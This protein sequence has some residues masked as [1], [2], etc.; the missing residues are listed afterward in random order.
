MPPALFVGRAAELERFARVADSLRL[1]LV[2]G[3]EGIGKTAFLLRAA[4]DL[5]A[6]K[7][8]RLVY[9]PCRAGESAVSWATAL[10]EQLGSARR[11]DPIEALVAEAQAAPIVACL[12]DVHLV[13]DRSLVDAL[14]HLAERQL[15]LWLG[16]ASRQALPVSPVQVDHLVVR[17]EGLPPDE[18][19]SLWQGLA[20]LY[21]APLI[22][23]GALQLGPVSPL[24]LKRAF[25]SQRWDAPPDTDPL[26]LSALPP[27]ERALLDQACAFRRP[28]P[29]P[30]LE[31]VLGR[32]ELRRVA[33]RLAARF[34]VEWQA[35]GVLAVPNV[36]REVVA[37][38]VQEHA[39]CVRQLRGAHGPGDEL[40]LLYHA[41]ACGELALALEILQRYAI[42]LGR[43]PPGSAVAERHLAE[44]ID[45]LPPSLPLPAGVR[46]L[47]ARIRARQGNPAQACD[48][49]APLV[50]EE[51]LAGLDLGAIA[52]ALGRI[53]LAIP[54]LTR[55]VHD[56]RL[57]PLIRILALGTLAG[58][59]RHRG[60]ISAA[61]R[62]LEDHR[63]LFVQGGVIGAG[64]RAWAQAIL[65]HECEDYPRAWT[66]LEAARRA[67]VESAPILPSLPVLASVEGAVAAALG[68]PSPP[69]APGELF[70][71]TPFFRYS[72]RLLRVEELWRRGEVREAALLAEALVGEA[73]AI[74]YP[75]V[76]YGAIALLVEAERILGRLRPAMARVEAAMPVAARIA[77]RAHLRL[78]AAEARLFL[79][80]GELPRARDAAFRADEVRDAP[81]TR[82]RLKAAGLLAAAGDGRRVR[83]RSERQAADGP[84]GFDAVEWRL[85]GCE[86]LLWEGRLAAAAEEADAVRAAAEE[87]GWRLLACR[88]KLARAE[89]AYRSGDLADAERL[90]AA[91]FAVADAQG[92][93]AERLWAQ[94]LGAG[95]Q[96]MRGDDAAANAA[97]EDARARAGESGFRVEEE[98]ARIGLRRGGR[99]EPERGAG[100]QDAP[101]V[102]LARRLA[103]AEAPRLKL[104]DAAGVRFLTP[105]L[106]EELDGERYGLFIDLVRRRVKVARRTIDL[107]RRG[108]LL[109]LV[110]VLAERPGVR[111]PVERLTRETWG[112]DYHPMRHHSRVTMAVSRLR[113]LIGPKLLEGGPD[114][115]RLTD[116]DPWA[117]VEPR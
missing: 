96:R 83:K 12:D 106:L 67:L 65:A 24:S 31:T 95:L 21:G 63:S 111:V 44:A 72:A 61:W 16:V 81:G 1:A 78:E 37:P 70:D 10:L 2:Y 26:G 29:L 76:E 14:V 9:L 48:E 32:G 35:G 6:R 71:E 3:V 52:V 51:P 75:A 79:A 38:G 11:S 43:V 89:A 88:A 36:V 22:E 46:L 100:S 45:R 94:L 5:A 49:I 64:I 27:D 84:Y 91:A 73:A 7:G 30:V 90:Q 34:L 55:V 99:K 17:L 66:A 103:L 41:V 20:E 33:D 117:V 28:T 104:R 105:G 108:S 112:V 92:Y 62:V 109:D 59:H 47:R 15:P 102:R 42:E 4:R 69:V 40:E 13:T 50:A 58:A 56:E 8:A 39:R 101:G 19:R 74:G 23:L 98:A 116:A 115:Y 77:L 68:R 85:A 54:A 97:L 113:S 18:A 60:A 53:D 86:I 25:A 107:S 80:S 114:G 57:G 93:A 82:A 110:R 87:G